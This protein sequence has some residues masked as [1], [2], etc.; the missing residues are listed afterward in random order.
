MTSLSLQVQLPSHGHSFFISVPTGSTVLDLKETIARECEG[1]PRV[2][3]QRIISKGRILSDQE[4]VEN[5]W[6]GPVNDARVLFLAVNPSAWASTP[7]GKST[8]T[9]TASTSQIGATRIGPPIPL[10]MFTSVP[11]TVAGVSTRRRQSFPPAYIHY[12]HGNAL[13]ALSRSPLVA[14]MAAGEIPRSRSWSKRVVESYGKVWPAILDEDFPGDLSNEGE[15]VLYEPTLVNGS[16]YY[17]LSPSSGQTPTPVQARAMEILSYTMPLLSLTYQLPLSSPWAPQHT[18]LWPTP[19]VNPYSVPAPGP[20]PAHPQNVRPI[21][22]APAFPRIQLRAILGPLFLLSLRT[23][24]L[25]YFFSPAR[26][27]VIAIAVVFWV[28]WEMWAVVQA[29]IL[30][31]RPGNENPNRGLANLNRPANNNNAQGAPNP[32]ARGLVPN[33]IPGLTDLARNGSTSMVLNT[34]AELNLV[35]E[36]NALFGQSAQARRSPSLFHRAKMFVSLFV[37]TLHPAIWLRRRNALRV[38]EG[39]LK[40][41]RHEARRNQTDP[42]QGNGGDQPPNP[43]LP[44]RPSWTHDYLA[45]TERAEWVDD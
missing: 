12:I 44:Q 11:S 1:R 3:G 41:E 23:A 16:P 6:Q 7:P 30:P 15:G 39:R 14:P 17:A 37:L 10:S 21:P 40:N 13:R 19:S 4:L 8:P 25:L 29:A 26:K 45:R 5:L 35:N 22:P 38:R 42:S 20:I 36:D 24:F 27:P 43:P 33:G 32:A 28:L 34:L 9:A 2:D 31:E 18:T